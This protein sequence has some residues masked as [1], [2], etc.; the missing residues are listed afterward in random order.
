MTD[1]GCYLYKIQPIRPDMLAN[2]STLQ[3][4]EIIDEHFSYLSALT[5]RGIVLLAGRTLNIDP[6]SFGIVILKA[7]SVNSAR[8]VMLADP[9]VFKGVMRAE[10]FPFQIA[11][12]SDQIRI[13]GVSAI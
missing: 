9:A 3:E 13:T 12:C 1:E 2:G 8:A 7:A 4:E 5:T 6:S 11:L 10:L